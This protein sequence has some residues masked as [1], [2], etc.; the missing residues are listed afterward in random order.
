MFL[1]NF[2]LVGFLTCLIAP[3][4]AVAALDAESRLPAGAGTT[5]RQPQTALHIFVERVQAESPVIHGAQAAIEA[6]QARLDGAR[7]PLYNPGLALDA[8]RTDVNTTSIGLSQTIDWGDKR[9]VRYRMAETELAAARAELAVVRRQV[10]SEVLASLAR[11]QT[12][13][14][15]RKLAVRRTRLMRDFAETAKQRQ[16]AG[17]VSQLDLALA[18][19][20]YTEARMQQ[21]NTDAALIAAETALRGVSGI[22]RR[23]WPSL[24][25]ALPV[26]PESIDI[27]AFVNNL[28]E[29]TA[30]RRRIETAKARIELT[31]R[32]RRPDPTIGVRGGREDSDM[33]LGLTL[34]VP[35]FVRNSF[36]AEVQEASQEALQAEQLMRENRRRAQARLEG[37]MAGYR[38]AAAAWRVWVEAGQSSLSEQIGL[39]EKLWKVGELSATEYL[40]QAGQNVDTQATAAELAGQVW[41]AAIDWLDASGQIEQWLNQAE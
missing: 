1:I 32:E 12:A 27:D 4:W 34:E 25:E 38:A 31:R 36:R 26:L 14:E 18:R 35:L 23:V 39:L 8:E 19:V 13:R 24:P 17:D 3:T 9:R 37:T 20:A 11:Y 41:L 16:Q 22:V 10:I 29:L 21:G 5:G 6:A 40:I 33:L 15:R 2:S 28:P 30:Q 7:R